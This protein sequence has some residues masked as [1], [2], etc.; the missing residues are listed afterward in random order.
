MTVCR[1]DLLVTCKLI[2]LTA[3]L[4]FTWCSSVSIY[5]CS[6]SAALIATASLW[7][8]KKRG[9]KFCL[10]PHFVGTCRKLVLLVAF[11]PLKSAE[12]LEGYKEEAERHSWVNLIAF[13]Q[14]QVAVLTGWQATLC[15][16]GRCALL[17][18]RGLQGKRMQSMLPTESQLNLFQN[19]WQCNKNKNQFW[20]EEAEPGRHYRERSES[21]CA[22]GQLGI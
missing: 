1:N 17:N 19:L 3:N 9:H 2:L 10:L 13:K 8:R 15:K 22:G 14:Q 4:T 16:W 20:R 21:A 12:E 5:Y 18:V 6:K 7:E 11:S